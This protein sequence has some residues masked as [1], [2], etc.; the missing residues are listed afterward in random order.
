[1]QAAAPDAVHAN[2]PPAASRSDRLF[3]CVLLAV[4]AVA[5]VVSAHL[6]VGTINPD[7]IAYVLNAEHYLRGYFGLAVNGYWGAMFSWMTAG[8]LA[9]GH[10][11]RG[12]FTF[13]SLPSR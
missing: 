2:V 1:M 8:L 9:C 13:C 7:G 3:L 4:Q 11:G 6:H 12:G 5:S 10:E